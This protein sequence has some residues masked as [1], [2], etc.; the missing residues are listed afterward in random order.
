MLPALRVVTNAGGHLRVDLVRALRRSQPHAGLFLMYGLT[1]A[2]RCTYLPPEEV[3]RHPDS[4]G[5]AIP[6]AEVMVINE[7]GSPAAP[8]EVGELVHR[9][10]TVTLGYWRDPALSAR[11][12]RPNPLRPS[13]A[14]DS[15]RVVYTGDLVRRDEEG[16]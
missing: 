12:F 11:V 2:M 9:G 16:L 5:R 6:G 7:D 8:G 4:I 15:E 3:D 13:G 1:E 10:P 14:P